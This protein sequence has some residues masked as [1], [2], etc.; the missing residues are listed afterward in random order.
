MAHTPTH[1]QIVA[2]SVQAHGGM[3]NTTR[4]VTTLSDAGYRPAT[5]RAAEKAARRALRKLARQGLLLK[6]QDRPVEYRATNA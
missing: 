4:T 5:R 3:W 2:R 1:S 6:V